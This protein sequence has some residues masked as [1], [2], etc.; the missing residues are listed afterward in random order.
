MKEVKD[1][2]VSKTM[3]FNF[4]YFT[5]LEKNIGLVEMGGS[6]LVRE[7]WEEMYNYVKFNVVI[8]VLKYNKA[9][10]DSQS[11]D[12][13]SMTDSKNFSHH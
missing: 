4:E 3:G 1:H 12:L 5:L 13:L 2:T 9:I 8:F 6:D 7:L 10:F 11:N